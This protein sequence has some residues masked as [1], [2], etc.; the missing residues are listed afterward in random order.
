MTDQGTVDVLVVGAG[1]GGGAASLA[2]DYF[3]AELG[4]KPLSILLID[5]HDANRTRANTILLDFNPTYAVQKF[6]CDISGFTPSTDWCQVCPEENVFNRYPL[7]AYEDQKRGHVLFNAAFML[8]RKPVFDVGINYLESILY[9]QID[10]RK[11]VRR[12]HST[13]LIEL[14]RTAQDLFCVTL[15]QQNQR[16]KVFARYIIVADGAKSDTLSLI[17]AR[18]KG[19]HKLE[20][21]VSANFKQT[22]VGNTKY[23]NN[24]R[25]IEALS[26]ATAQG[27]SVFVKVP[28]EVCEEDYK[29]GN[30]RD[31]KKFKNILLGGARKLG[32]EGDIG[33]GF[34]LI[35]IVLQRSSRSIYERN[36]LVIGDARHATTPRVALGA[37]VA[38]MDAIRAAHTIV[39]IHNGPAWRAQLAR[40]YFS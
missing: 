15:E 39:T 32:V 22:G 16:H 38:I 37:N 6:G 23:H 29:L 8:R 31:Q 13:N 33:F 19:T 26:L 30:D 10:K 1:P 12:V 40:A 27:T 9:E 4:A 11:N 18:K 20:T 36:I 5:K 14:T 7:P 2:I 3:S 34:S 25:S 17:G 28:E 24:N 21:L 35:P